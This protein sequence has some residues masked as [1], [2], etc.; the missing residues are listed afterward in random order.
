MTIVNG[1]DLSVK[2][3]LEAAERAVRQGYNHLSKV[4]LGTRVPSGKGKS[5]DILY[6]HSVF[7]PIDSKLTR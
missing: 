4:R 7:Y 1:V 2:A 3:N 6:I 5:K